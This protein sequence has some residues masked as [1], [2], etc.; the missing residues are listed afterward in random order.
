M[1]AF[2]CLKCGQEY[3]VKPEFAG[4]RTKCARCGEPIVVPQPPSEPEEILDVS[5]ELL[6]SDQAPEGAPEPLEVCDRLLPPDHGRDP[7]EPDEPLDALPVDEDGSWE[8]E[9]ES[10]PSPEPKKKEE[11]ILDALPAPAEYLEEVEVDPRSKKKKAARLPVIHGVDAVVKIRGT[12]VVIDYEDGYEPE[13]IHINAIH[14]VVLSAPVFGG[15]GVIRFVMESGR[16]FSRR[17]GADEVAVTF[18]ASE[19]QAATAF[20]QV[21][22]SLWYRLREEYRMRGR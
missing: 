13:K 21:V 9:R 2:A 22:D 19:T 10:R 15:T 14:Q 20:K 16:T 3:T 1:I 6:P 12:N 5:D 17:D 18:P 7:S 8:A 11:K 4:R